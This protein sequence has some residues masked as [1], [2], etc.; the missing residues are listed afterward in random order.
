MKVKP[1][2]SSTPA[3]SV[4][5][6]T[7][8]TSAASLQY[9]GQSDAGASKFVYTDVLSGQSYDFEFNLQYYNPSIGNFPNIQI[10][11]AYIFCPDMK[12]QK[13]HL[14]SAFKSVEVH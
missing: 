11:G 6:D 1:Q 3:P 9:S 14:Y 10:S 12:D 8:S 5:T 2:E 7:I 13:S 4:D